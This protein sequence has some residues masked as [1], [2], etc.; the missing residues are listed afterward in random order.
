MEKEFST[1]YVKDVKIPEVILNDV[2]WVN[3]PM[4]KPWLQVEWTTGKRVWMIRSWFSAGSPITT[5]DFT[6]FWFTPSSYTIEAWYDDQSTAPC[7][8]YSSYVNWAVRWW[9]SYP[10]V[11]TWLMSNR[12]IAVY[13]SWT[14]RTLAYHSAFLSDW[15]RLN[16]T[17]SWV[18]VYF[19]LT[20]FE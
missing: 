4:Y 15:V 3:Q 19:I 18:N 10:W 1:E 14:T 17:V 7:V 9:L 11:Y 6:W 20:A 12:M 5:Y 13:T 2:P 8:S 16:L